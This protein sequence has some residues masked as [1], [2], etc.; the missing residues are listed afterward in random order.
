MRV[1]TGLGLVWC[2]LLLTYVQSA[3]PVQPGSTTASTTQATTTVAS[4]SP[5]IR[6]RFDYDRLFSE[7]YNETACS[8]D[9]FRCKNGRCILKRWQCDGEKDCADGSDEDAEKCQTKVC[10]SEEFT[11]RSGTG[12]CIPLSWMCD[13][14]RDCADGSDESTCS[15]Y[16]KWKLLF[17]FLSSSLSL[18]LPPA[19]IYVHE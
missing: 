13:Q 7:N 19:L 16:S 15:E 3:V 1:M 18:P 2:V 5:T 14:N 10:S 11:C 9:K 12:N 8:E 17:P 4:V 6:R